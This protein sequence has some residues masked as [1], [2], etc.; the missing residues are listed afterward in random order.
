MVAAGAAAV[1][2]GIAATFR[3]T[4]ALWKRRWRSSGGVWPGA[5]PLLT[6]LLI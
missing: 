2:A 1:A 3:E 4:M 6:L 5:E